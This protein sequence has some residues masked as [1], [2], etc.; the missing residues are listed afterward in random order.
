[1][2]KQYKPVPNVDCLRYHGTPEQPDIKIFISRRIDINSV[3]VDNPLFVPV[4]CGAVYDE[5]SENSPYIGDD[6]GD[7]I[8]EKR[9]IFSEFTVQYWA[10]KNL[11]A[12]YYG[13][14]HYRRYLSFAEKKY[15]TGPHGLVSNVFLDKKTMKRFGLLDEIHMRNIISHHDLVYPSIPVSEIITP[16]GHVNSVRELWDAHIGY[17]FDEG[18]I[19]RVLGYI[20]ALAP[21]FSISAREYFSGDIHLG[22]NCY[23]MRKELFTRMCCLQFPIMEALEKEL[24]EEGTLESFSRTPSYAGEMLFGVFLYHIIKKETWRYC[25]KQILLFEETEMVN[26]NKAKLTYILHKTREKVWYISLKIFPRGSRRRVF[27]KRLYQSII[28]RLRKN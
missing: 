25:E 1:M 20:D 10:W 28:G 13:L 9:M 19:D 8:S 21:E 11:K 16:K 24:R 5:Q 2:E 15:R 26:G 12:D 6:T 18:L 4:C 22:Y 3:T 23:V 7:N 14:C 27:L 17:F